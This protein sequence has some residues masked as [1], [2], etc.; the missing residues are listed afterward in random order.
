MTRLSV[1]ELRLKANGRWVDILTALGIPLESLTRQNKPCPACGGTDRF[2]F[3]DSQGSGSF[4]CRAIHRQ[5]G[6]G[7]ELA[8][9]WLN[10]DFRGAL[11]AVADALGGTAA[12]PVAVP[13]TARPAPAAARPDNGEALRKLWKASSPI[14]PADPVGLYLAGRGLH[15]VAALPVLRCHPALPYWHTVHGHPCRLGT[16]PAML[17]AVQGKEGRTVALHRTYLTPAGEKAAPQD[18]DTGEVLPAK[19]LKTRASKV[20]PG[21]AVRLFSPA[22][23]R[24]ALTEGIETGL[25]VH[26]VSG[27]PVWS[28][29]SANGLCTVALPPEIGEVFIAGDN[30]ESE[31]GQRAAEI[32]ATRL[33]Q[34]GRRVEII[35]PSATGLDW[36]DVLNDAE[37]CAA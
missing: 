18:P 34:E 37:R 31:T 12:V 29:V 21:A 13:P 20:M 36:L 32:L 35:T 15:L 16:Y 30:D 24:L 17:A 19:K 26:L 23:G 27:L 11:A 8:R 22:D 6:D 5:G 1:S 3:T 2:S 28:C 14:S 33:R 25:A 7:F 10:C 4:V 9:H